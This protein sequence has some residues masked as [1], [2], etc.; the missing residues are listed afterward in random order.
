MLPIRISDS[1]QAAAAGIS[2]VPVT[3]NEYF[4]PS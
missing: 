3:Q 1:S 4:S 2:F